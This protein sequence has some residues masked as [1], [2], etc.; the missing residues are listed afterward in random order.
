MIVYELVCTQQ[1][2]FE[3]WFASA[4]DFERQ[5]KCGMLSCPV[6]ADPD[7]AKL[8]SARI[9]GFAQ[10][11]PSE[12][13]QAAPS[14]L[15]FHKQVAQLLEAIIANTDDVGRRFAEEARRIHYEEAPRRPIRGVATL[16]ETRELIE[17]GIAVLPLPIPPREEMN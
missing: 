3:G 6:C 15:E 4:E 10:P 1:H 16:S 9:G 7:I 5:R 8:P 13:Q 2:R 11:E 12:Q 17:E 14:A